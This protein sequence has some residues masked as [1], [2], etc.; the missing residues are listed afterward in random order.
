MHP[1]GPVVVL[2]LHQA[3]A[4]P[5][6][7]CQ[8][9][10]RVEGCGVQVPNSTP[11]AKCF[12]PCPNA[13]PLSVECEGTPRC[14]SSTRLLQIFHDVLFALSSAALGASIDAPRIGVLLLQVLNQISELITRPD[15]LPPFPNENRRVGSVVVTDPLK[16][17]SLHAAYLPHVEPTPLWSRIAPPS[18]HTSRRWARP[19]HSLTCARSC[20]GALGT[21]ASGRAHPGPSSP[22]Q[23]RTRRPLSVL[24]G[25]F[26]PL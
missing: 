13:I 2:A 3:G 16:Q 10:E 6:P 9:V 8:R 15:K 25:L 18:D 21:P 14:R 24:P 7:A 26:G 22:P 4:S 12:V 17:P 11:T 5:P 20:R 23:A 19:A 1:A